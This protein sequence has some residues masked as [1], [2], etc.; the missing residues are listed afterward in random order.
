MNVPTRDRYT[1]M[2]QCTVRPCVARSFV[3]LVFGLAS[4]M[5]WTAPLSTGGSEPRIDSRHKP[6]GGDDGEG[7]RAR[8]CKEC[9]SGAGFLATIARSAASEFGAR[10]KR[11]KRLYFRRYEL[12]EGPHSGCLLHVAVHEQIEG[13]YQS[14]IVDDPNKLTLVIPLKMGQR[15]KPSACFHC[16]Y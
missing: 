13:Q 5:G 8:Y 4:M 2:S 1:S 15:R 11:A 3:D 6:G 12:G 10:Q 9:I 7:D 16:E 14:D